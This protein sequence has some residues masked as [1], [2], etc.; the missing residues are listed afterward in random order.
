[1]LALGKNTVS[2]RHFWHGNQGYPLYC[3]DKGCAGRG[4]ALETTFG[5]LNAGLIVMA[6]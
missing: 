6:W 2:L 4:V 1:V 5:K 3:D